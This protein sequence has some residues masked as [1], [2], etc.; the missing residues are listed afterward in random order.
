M[1]SPFGRCGPSPEAGEEQGVNSVFY[2]KA[3]T[4]I[5]KAGKLTQNG[6]V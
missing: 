4:P 6:A 3:N 2:P 1:R 5:H